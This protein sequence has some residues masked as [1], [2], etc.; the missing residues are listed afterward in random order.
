M[1]KKYNTKNLYRKPKKVQEPSTEQGTEQAK[2]ERMFLRV[3]ED[4][5]IVIS[6]AVKNWCE[7]SNLVNRVA[8][9]LDCEKFTKEDLN[10]LSK[11]PARFDK[12][13]AL[14]QSAK[15]IADNPYMA[16]FVSAEVQKKTREK[17][18]SKERAKFNP[19]DPNLLKYAVEDENG[20]LHPDYN[21]ILED[22]KIYLSGYDLQAYN[23]NVTIQQCAR[24][25]FR[26][27]A[28][29]FG[30]SIKALW[31]LFQ[32]EVAG[33]NMNA[34]EFAI[35]KDLNLRIFSELKNRQEET[36]D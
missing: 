12:M 35:R 21:A 28:W 14:E 24:R 3:D 16:D 33:Y 23:D 32:P 20:D 29:R 2:T 34:E 15:Y 4:R 36:A 13:L 1:E 22:C 9:E 31:C 7:C 30:G 27:Q 11:N 17:W 6:T 10:E 8:K 5:K 26:G 18:T 19:I 25:L